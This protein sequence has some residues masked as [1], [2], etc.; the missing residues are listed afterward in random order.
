MN[1]SSDF[2]KKVTTRVDQSLKFSIFFFRTQMNKTKVDKQLPQFESETAKEDNGKLLSGC[3]L[4]RIGMLLVVVIVTVL[5]LLWCREAWPVWF[6]FDSA[7]SSSNLYRFSRLWTWFGC[8]FGFV[9]CWFDLLFVWWF[10]VVKSL[11]C[12]YW[13]I[14][15]SGKVH[16]V[17]HF[18]LA[19]LLCLI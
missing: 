18:F 4:V 1:P 11:C 15:N 13:W 8:Y 7:R 5:D 10:W 16:D 2:G 12:Y 17:L 3:S 9:W 6:F 19:F 14:W